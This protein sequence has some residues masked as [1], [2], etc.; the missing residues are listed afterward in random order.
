MLDFCFIMWYIIII[1]YRKQ[2]KR[3]TKTWEDL[4]VLA[5]ITLEYEGVEIITAV[6]KT[7]NNRDYDYITAKMKT[8]SV[9][10]TVYFVYDEKRGLLLMDDEEKYKNI[11]KKYWQSEKDM[12]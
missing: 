9:D 6:T 11:P 4:W 1:R 2:T 12:I 8:L 3:R 5:L 7:I 10:R